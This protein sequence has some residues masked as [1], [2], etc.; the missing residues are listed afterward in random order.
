MF[1]K[2]LQLTKD[3]DALYLRGSAKKNIENKLEEAIADLEAFL[4]KAHPH[5]RKIPTGTLDNIC[6]L[7]IS[8]LFSCVVDNKR[9]KFGKV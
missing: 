3:A 7:N 4:E 5:E 2:L 9:R 8:L 6:P 1:D